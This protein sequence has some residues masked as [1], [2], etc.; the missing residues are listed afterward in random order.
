MPLTLNFTNSATCVQTRPQPLGTGLLDFHW[1]GKAAGI[2]GGLPSAH[3]DF[4]FYP[5][6]QT[7]R[8]KRKCLR[9]FLLCR[10]ADIINVK[11]AFICHA[12]ER[13]VSWLARSAGFSAFA[14]LK[15]LVYRHGAH[16]AQDNSRQH[17]RKKHSEI[18]HTIPP[19]HCTGFVSFKEFLIAL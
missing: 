7:R 16:P 1:H 19:M 18:I 15:L 2:P 13:G 6:L 4:Y 3:I 11:L 5:P 17:E 14:A 8:D 10:C 12:L 9:G